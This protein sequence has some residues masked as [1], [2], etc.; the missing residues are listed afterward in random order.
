MLSYRA[1]SAP[2]EL[3]V[4][5]RKMLKGSVGDTAP[6]SMAIDSMKRPA[7][8]GQSR[9]FGQFWRRGDVDYRHLGYR[10]RKSVHFRYFYILVRITFR[11]NVQIRDREQ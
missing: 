6:E 2:Y 1:V 11:K 10:F 3:S 4:R 7:E 9:S 8:K 5:T